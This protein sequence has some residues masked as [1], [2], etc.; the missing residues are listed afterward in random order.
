LLSENYDRDLRD[1][2]ILQSDV[3]Q[4]V[5]QKIHIALTPQEQT[6]LAVAKPINPEAYDSLLRGRFYLN[7]QTKA[8]N[9][10]AIQMFDR[11]VAIDPNFALAQAE[12]AQACVW[13]FF[14]FTP[15]EKQW[16]VKAFV[17]VQK[18]LLLDPNLAEAH[19]ARGRLLWTPSNHF[20][21]DEAIQEYRRALELNPNLDEARN[22]LAVVYGHIGLLEEALQELD[23]AVAVNPGNTLARYRIGETYL[24]QGNYEQALKI[25]QNVPKEAN[26]SLVGHQS[27]WALFNLGKKDEAVATL[28]QFLKDYPED[29]RGLFTSLQAVL[30][31]SEG[32]PDIAEAKIKLAIERGKGFGH[33]HH[34]AYHIA[35]A[36]ALMNKVEQAMKWLETTANDGFPCYPM[37]ERDMNLN[38]LRKDPRFVTFLAK[39]K[40]QWEEHRVKAAGKPT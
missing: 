9:E 20:P 39:L 40:Q 24:F 27:V 18:A 15:D 33:F 16:E 4:A 14:L 30:A 1:I 12:L 6:R 32:Q 5:T 34:T 8:D 3:A 2:L 31:A 21:H 29:N 35:C 23:K 36:Y 25:L 28:E 13:R 22:Q 37:F 19:L 26:P 11:S 10:T 17:A 38:N 7:R